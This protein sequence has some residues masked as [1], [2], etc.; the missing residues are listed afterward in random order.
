V[1]ID[2]EAAVVEK[3]R[4]E[5]ARLHDRERSAQDLGLIG[6]GGVR[7]AAADGPETQDRGQ[8]QNAGDG[9]LHARRRLDRIRHEAILLAVLWP[10][11]TG[12]AGS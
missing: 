8:Q 3:L 10:A 1:Q 5:I 9:E 12:A 4:I 2:R 6:T 11:C 7:D